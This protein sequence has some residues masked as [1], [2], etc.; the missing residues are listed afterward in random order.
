M[1]DIVIPDGVFD[2]SLEYAREEVDD[3]PLKA[4][5]D[6]LEA[7]R[8]NMLHF[9]PTHGKELEYDRKYA[10]IERVI[11]EKRGALDD[12]YRKSQEFFIDD[13]IE[14]HAEDDN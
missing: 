6:G 7:R 8:D 1:A 9:G 2:Q 11:S 13:W 12:L 4:E 5:V 10:E 14:N 3:S